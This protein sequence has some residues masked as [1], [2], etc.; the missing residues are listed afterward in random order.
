MKK[1]YVDVYFSGTKRIEVFADNGEEAVRLAEK[2]VLKEDSDI[3]AVEGEV[4]NSERIEDTT[5]YAD[6]LLDEQR[7]N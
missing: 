4:I 2:E 6:M 5:E 7:G 1:F 3:D